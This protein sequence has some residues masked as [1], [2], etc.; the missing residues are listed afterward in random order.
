MSDAALPV[1][2]VAAAT[3]GALPAAPPK[4]AI[5]P[6]VAP[7]AAVEVD[8]F[9][10]Y[11]VDGK[12]TRLNK[13][14]RKLHFQKHLAADKRLKEAADEKNKAA[15]LIK[16]FETDPEAALTKAGHDPSKIFGSHL[17]KRAKLEM[18]T[19]E[20]RVAMALQQRAEAAETKAA[21]FEEEK[22][23]QYRANVDRQNFLAVE[24]QFIE[25]ANKHGLDSS[26]EV[27]RDMCDI[28]IEFLEHDLVITADQAALEYQRREAD[29]I[30][31]RDKRR[32][33]GLKGQKLLTYLGEATVAEVK[34][35]LAA[36]DAESLQS[37]PKPQAK[38]KTQVKAHERAIKGSHISELMFDKKF[39]L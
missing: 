36:A 20:Q 15:D 19:E 27:L 12:T 5:K 7:V 25:T 10:E 26:P 2:P 37:I 32:S 39:G 22:R 6:P 34:A 9:E 11:V 3:N 4:T 17:E 33:A 1:A 28:A 23:A 35:A 38:P 30:E 13:E 16:L 14:Q 8:D 21:K 18:M 29:H 31:A 24:Q